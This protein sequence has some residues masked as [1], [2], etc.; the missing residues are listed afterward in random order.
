MERSRTDNGAVQ[1]RSERRQGHSHLG[2]GGA[3]HSRSRSRSN[4]IRE[5]EHHERHRRRRDDERQ[6]RRPAEITGT[7]DR[8]TTTEVI[9]TSQAVREAD[10]RQ[11]ARQIEHQSSLRSLMSASDID[12]A[13]EEEILRQIIDEGL[14]E[15]INLEDLDG[16]QEDEL[17]ERIAEAYR[18][19]H[20]SRRLPNL[21]GSPTAETRTVRQRRSHSAH[22]TERRE[23]RPTPPA[24]DLPPVSR[25]HLLGATESSS[26]LSHH[27]RRAFDQGRRQTSPNPGTTRTNSGDLVSHQ[28]TRSATDL[29]N[30]PQSSDAVRTRPRHSSEGRRTNTEPDGPRLTD[31][32]RNAATR[33]HTDS[34]R[35]A[36]DQETSISPPHMSPASD[37]PPSLLDIPRSNPTAASNDS[38]SRPSTSRSDSHPTRT[39]ERQRPP[40]QTNAEGLFLEPYLICDRCYRPNI[41]Y[42]LHKHCSRC[43][44]NLCLQCYRQKRGCNH[45]FGFGTSAMINFTTSA[46]RSSGSSQR[47]PP[48]VLAGR[49]YLSPP[50]G[51]T[52][53]TEID[54]SDGNGARPQTWTSS[55]PATRLQE[56]K[57]CDRCFLF[58]NPC[59]WS[60][61]ACNEGEWGFCNDCVNTQHC[62]THP[63][64]PLAHK[65]FAPGHEG[66][67]TTTTSRRLSTPAYASIL[68][69][70]LSLA[71]SRPSSSDGAVEL[72]GSP[73]LTPTAEADIDY[74]ALTFTTHCDICSYPIPPS[75]TR[76]HCPFHEAAVNSNRGPGDYDICTACYTRL[77]K[78][79]AISSSNGV[80]GWRRCPRG[81]RMVITG[82]EERGEGQRR[83]V[84]Q[85][86]VGGWA[87]KDEYFEKNTSNNNNNNNHNIGT[88]SWREGGSEG[89]SP[90]TR[91]SRAKSLTS[92]SATTTFPPSG[93]VGL[94]CQ[95]TWSYL[96]DAEEDPDAKDE[97]LFPRGAEIREA[98]DINGD[99]FWGVYMGDKGVF[100][101]N[102]A[103]VVGSVGM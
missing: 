58:A 91:A 70:P 42:K 9:P 41:Q 62:C 12:G 66:D 100:P 75:S 89:S 15:G 36:L 86:L 97:L 88:W 53:R 48:H 22:S 14:L 11:R 19:R 69:L 73:A 17:S 93:G 2:P 46:P 54:R 7:S 99:W 18:Q 61:A 47:E 1:S 43:S 51:V 35:F 44:M 80:N 32:W 67:D 33:E 65:D 84:V 76:F 59:F 96:P 40:T 5:R 56:G 4:E 68:P 13:M 16:A 25:P 6:R 30:R 27:R 3:S 81:H 55:D 34:H 57:F 52:L 92:S 101:G 71:S 103:Q 63:L 82:F 28:A 20:P 23:D 74:V 38:R 72:E 21:N 24:R 98:E 83:V 64:L 8:S 45:W 79:G 37:L 39:R 87:L 95:A 94:H 29:S 49:K 77:T 26:S 10:D 90:S 102:Y 78:T 31:M 50:S 60:C 85:D